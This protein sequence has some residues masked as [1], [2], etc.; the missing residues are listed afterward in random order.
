MLNASYSTAAVRRSFVIEYRSRRTSFADDR[1]RH[2]AA[3]A[4]IDQRTP[5]PVPRIFAI[6]IDIH[7]EKIKI[8]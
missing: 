8:L 5:R 7:T 3:T 4:L 1:R 6:L 2:V